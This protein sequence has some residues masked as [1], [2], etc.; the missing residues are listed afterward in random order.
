MLRLLPQLPFH[1]PDGPQRFGTVPL[2][3]LAD[4]PTFGL[5]RH[6]SMHAGSSPE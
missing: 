5:L 6:L 2:G 3:R 1:F 4:I